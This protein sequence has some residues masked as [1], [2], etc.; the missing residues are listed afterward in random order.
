MG[1]ATTVTEIDKTTEYSK[2][3]LP[4]TMK[5]DESPLIPSLNL[6]V[7]FLQLEHQ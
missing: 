4:W 3:R 7:I 1:Q 2:L 5:T 6:T